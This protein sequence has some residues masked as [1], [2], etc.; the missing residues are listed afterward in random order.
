VFRQPLVELFDLLRLIGNYL[1]CHCLHLRILAILE[2]GLC[3]IE[4]GL[5]VRPHH[6]SE[7]VVVITSHLHARH[8]LVHG[9]HGLHHIVTRHVMVLPRLARRGPVLRVLPRLR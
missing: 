4:A 7:I 8:L 5:M 9:L 1:F 6:H 3:H 2:L